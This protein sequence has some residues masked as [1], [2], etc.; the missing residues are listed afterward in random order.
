MGI[1]SPLLLALVFLGAGGAL[2]TWSSGRILKSAEHLGHI[3]RLPPIVTGALFIGL[4]TSLPEL[5]TS[6]TS[7]F[8]GAP[9]IVVPTIIGSNIFNILWIL[10][11]G[12]LF[13][14]HLRQESRG[15]KEIIAILL[16]TA[17]SL[18]LLF[19]GGFWVSGLIF[20]L[21][22]Y[23]CIRLILRPESEE[24]RI[25][26]HHPRLHHTIIA[27]MVSLFI[28]WVG[29]ELLI[30]GISDLVWVLNIDRGILSL[31]LVAFATSLPELV[32]SVHGYFTRRESLAFGNILGSTIVNPFLIGGVTSLLAPLPGIHGKQW[33]AALFTLIASILLIL[34]IAIK[35]TLPRWT[36]IVYILIF[37]IYVI[38]IFRP[39]IG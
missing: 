13:R 18:L 10:G 16:A 17:G 38:V 39:V 11:L 31:L 2:L 32:V 7:V 27:L 21:L 22:L 28:L 25:L 3:L 9:D 6:L 19:V 26:A 12:F 4:G 30:R 15:W 1:M 29:S 37:A 24:K 33:E 36:G 14:L 20:L 34:P 5:A 8:R 23:V 35:R